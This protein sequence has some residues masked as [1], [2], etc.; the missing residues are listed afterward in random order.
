RGAVAPARRPYRRGRGAGSLIGSALGRGAILGIE[1][2]AREGQQF[3]LAGLV[4][5][6]D[7]QDMPGE[8]GLV[9]ARV[10]REGGF[11]RSVAHHENFVIG[12]QGGCN[13]VEELLVLVLMAGAGRPRLVM[14]VAG[15][16][17]GAD[18]MLL[19]AAR[20]EFEDAR[21]RVIDPDDGVKMMGHEFLYC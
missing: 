16:V 1:E 3:A 10:V 11:G 19:D 7:A 4:D 9:I 14:D 13:R 18:V 21:L 5:R 15:P 12:F 20:A 17:L 2:F 6:L 8:V